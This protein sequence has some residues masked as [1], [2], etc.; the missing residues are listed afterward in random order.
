MWLLLGSSA[1]R[2]GN[3]CGSIAACTFGGGDAPELDSP[4]GM[5]PA[6]PARCLSIH[7][8]FDWSPADAAATAHTTTGCTFLG[9]W[10]ASFPSSN[11]SAKLESNWLPSMVATRARSCVFSSSRSTSSFTSPRV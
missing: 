7:L 5:Y 6:L 1:L 10:L 11:G 8:R 3:P 9:V 2:Y 4:T